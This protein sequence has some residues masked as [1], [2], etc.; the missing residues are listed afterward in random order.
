MGA[1]RTRGDITLREVDGEGILY[2]GTSGK[3][4]ILNRTA[5]AVWECLALGLGEKGI[6]ARLEERFETDGA[7]LAQDVAGIVAQFRD[8]GLLEER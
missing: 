8:A 7:D 6:A 1:L 5:H 3:I 2:D 4:H